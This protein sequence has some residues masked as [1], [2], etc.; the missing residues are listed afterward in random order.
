MRMNVVQVA[1]PAT[2]ATARGRVYARFF[3]GFRHHGIGRQRGGRDD[4]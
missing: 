3:A 4:L 2:L 1:L